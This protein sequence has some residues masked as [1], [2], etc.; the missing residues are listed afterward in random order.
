M[1]RIIQ[2]GNDVQFARLS[3]MDLESTRDGKNIF[4]VPK[5]PTVPEKVEKSV[6]KETESQE[7][8]KTPGPIAKDMEAI[9]EEAFTKGKIAG[10]QE[11][12]EKLHSSV[13]ALGAGLEQ[14]STLQKSLYSKSREDMVKLVMAIAR[15]VIRTEIE[16]KKEIIVD[17]VKMALKSAI[18]SDEYYI[19]VHPGDYKIITENE[20]LFLASMKGLQNIHFIA[21]ETISRGG[22]LA[23]SR[24][25]DVDA[26]IESQLGEIYGHLLETIK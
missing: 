17:T 14:I 1:S 23:E 13:Q 19:R 24:A 26:T 18:P 3:F 11:A 4:F 6:D 10:R 5:F 20:P 22:C 25:G 15:K 9:K 2:S 7:K 16:E 21:E 8:T 12:E